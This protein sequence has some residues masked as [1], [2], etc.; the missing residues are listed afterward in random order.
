MEA[1]GKKT[2]IRYK[3]LWDK[4]VEVST[5]LQ[6]MCC[7]L[8]HFVFFYFIFCFC[9]NV[10]WERSY[11]LALKNIHLDNFIQSHIISQ[12]HESSNEHQCFQ[13]HLLVPSNLQDVDQDQAVFKLDHQHNLNHHIY[14]IFN[15]LDLLKQYLS[16]F[17]YFS[18][19]MM[20]NVDMLYMCMIDLVLC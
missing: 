8:S 4:Q 13:I 18:Y 6:H 12:L 2:I 9:F 5:Y 20:S 19:K 11:L 14:W 1:L 7:L 17:N 15:N 10:G 3:F 16:F